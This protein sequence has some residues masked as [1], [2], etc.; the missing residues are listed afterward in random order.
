M[1]PAAFGW[2]IR[3]V[4]W[5]AMID[6]LL[7]RAM[8]PAPMLPEPRMVWSAALVRR[9]VPV[10]PETALLA[11]LPIVSTPP[12]VSVTSVVSTRPVARPPPTPEFIASVPVFVMVLARRVVVLEVPLPAS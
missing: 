8:T 11:A 5:V 4:V 3:G 10:L 6:P 1:T 9:W 12:P 2:T 7:V